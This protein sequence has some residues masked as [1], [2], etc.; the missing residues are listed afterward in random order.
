MGATTT[1]LMTFA[2]FEQLP[3]EV[4]GGTSCATESW[5]KCRRRFSNIV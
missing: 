2:E 4:A 1:K 5:L 3:D